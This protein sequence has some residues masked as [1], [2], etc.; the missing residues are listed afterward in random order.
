MTSL[1]GASEFADLAPQASSSSNLA[2]ASSFADLA[3]PESQQIL[4]NPV[5]QAAV[6]AGDAIRNTASSIIN[7]LRS[8]PSQEQ[9]QNAS[10]MIGGMA[11]PKI[12]TPTPFPMVNNSTGGS[13]T[14]YSLGNMAG[15]I[16]AYMGG[17]EGLAAARLGAEAVPGVV[18]DISKA[19][20]SNP[21]VT[22][23]IGNAA[24][25]GL[26]S[27]T[28]NSDQALKGADY[29]LA[30]DAIPGVARKLAQGAQYFMPQRYAQGIIQELGEGIP[31]GTSPVDDKMADATQSILSDIRQS[32]LTQRNNA[33]D[34]YNPVFN[35][36]S[37][38]SI[39]APIKRVYGIPTVAPTN[40]SVI[41]KAYSPVNYGESTGSSSLENLLSGKD[42][43]INQ[44]V[45]KNIS[46]TI[47]AAGKQNPASFLEG[48]YPNLSSSIT[49]NYTQDLNDLHDKFIEN[50][51]F[52]NAHD[53]QS[54]LGSEIGSLKS[55]LPSAEN[56]NAISGLSKARLGIK[57][58]MTT[59][60]NTQGNPISINAD[61]I[62]SGVITP[63]TDLA[64]QYKNASDSFQQN[65]VPYTANKKISPI[66]LGEQTNRKPNTLA[67]LFAAPD[68]NM[69]HVLGDLSGN[70]FDKI[71]YTKLG[72]TVPNKSAQGLLNSY[73]NLQQQGL[74]GYISQSLSSK[75]GELE[76][77]IKARNGLQMLSSAGAAASLGSLHGGATAGAMMG[78]GAG[79][80]ASPFMNYI[81]RRLPLDNFT[82]A[83]GNFARGAYPMGRSAT[84]ANTLNNSGVSNNGS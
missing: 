54:T 22:R 34:L 36:V 27:Q 57:N 53:L 33:S 5:G 28:N 55:E 66:A 38:G 47:V 69:T 21:I 19:I 60:L 9:M 61:D 16:A 79:A 23:A 70:T 40:T 76:N 75:L 17:G 84:L 7:N 24:Y 15:N 6:G 10:N 14:A 56:R 8:A 52:Q 73:Q 74:G 45:G 31:K 42:N 25:S 49:K 59:F 72:Q 78:L 65:V 68:E 39:Y 1:L 46:S 12:N 64:Q 13:P 18:G 50:P 51:T 48:Q 81:G 35:S 82:Q 29:S 80:I 41:S 83:I 58:D 4:N 20:G 77:R 32:Y 44:P 62:A 37:G 2:G 43:S 30:A 71:L 11:L 3:P 26:T 67:N 63:S